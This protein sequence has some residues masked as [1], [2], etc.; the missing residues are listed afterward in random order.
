[1][2]IDEATPIDLEILLDWAALEGWNPGIEDA[3]PFHSADPHGFFIGRVAGT[4]AAAISVVRSDESHAFLGFYICKPEF[5]G[6]GHGFA[7]WK[8]GLR[9]AEGCT[10]GLD[11]VVAQQER[12]AKSGFVLAWNNVRYGGHIAPGPRSRDGVR[13]VVPEDIARLLPFDTACYGA[14]RM[15]FLSA[16][17]GPS[18]SRKGF[19]CLR[20]GM[21]A[22]YCVVR[23]CRHG[24][25]VGPLFAVDPATARALLA[26]ALEVAGRSEIFLDVPLANKAAVKLAEEHGL[27]PKFETARMYRGTPP[28]VPINQIF[29]VTTFELS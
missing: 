17:L 10:I 7:L 23:R 18:K 6:L 22:G 29:G 15:A 3:A 20:D 9:H 24:F 14:S 5:R 28:S 2:E 27:R 12:Y 8:H 25:K 1:M 11:G 19:I 13:A 26:A 16:W 4:P 21:V